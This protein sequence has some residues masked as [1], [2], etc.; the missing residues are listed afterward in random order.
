MKKK[1]Y[2]IISII[3]LIFFTSACTGYKPIFGASQVG[4]EISS[5]SIEGN[6]K[7]G[8]QIYSQLYNVSKFNKNKESAR[9]IDILINVSKDKKATAKNSAGK[10]MEYKLTLS[11]KVIVKDYLSNNEILNRNFESFSSF[12]VQD[13]HSET[14]KLENKTIENLLNKTYQDLASEGMENQIDNYQFDVREIT[15]GNNSQIEDLFHRLNTNVFEN[16]P[17]ELRNAITHG[18][19]KS[20]ANELTKEFRNFLL[21][22]KIRTLNQ[23]ARQQD[24]ETV[25]NEILLL[26]VNG[27]ISGSDK[28]IKDE[29]YK[30][31]K[32]MGNKNQIRNNIIKTQNI[33]TRIFPEQDF[34]STMFTKHT[35]YLALFSAL[36]MAITGGWSSKFEEKLKFGYPDTDTKRR[37]LKRS[38]EDFSRD[39]TNGIEKGT[40][41]GGANVKDY[42]NAFVER[43]TTERRI[44]MR[45]ARCLIKVMEPNLMFIDASPGPTAKIRKELYTNWKKR[46]KDNKPICVK[47]NKKISSI[48]KM[49]V[50]HNKFKGKGGK[51]SIKNYQPEHVSCNRRDNQI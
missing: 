43:H 46:S 37:R 27:E 29:L 38:L 35:N 36:Y 2:Y 23:V 33:I 17:Q 32:T 47:C 44:R 24:T 21:N 30:N 4:F 18:D 39:V 41:R 9:S 3:L 14:M 28:K 49:D 11:T 40:I 25:I 45:K 20:L 16:N 1:N 50:G 10:I 12:K 19:L 42:V 6:K 34:V 31:N 22:N 15:G 13:Q 26:A 7:L 48:A 5:Y 51:N 8:N